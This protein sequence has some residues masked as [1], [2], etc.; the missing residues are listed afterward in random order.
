MDKGITLQLVKLNINI[1]IGARIKIWILECVGI[2]ISLHNSLKPS[3]NGCSRP[4]KPTTFGPRLRWIDAITLR[5]AKVKYATP[6]KINTILIKF[7]R[8]VPNQLNSHQ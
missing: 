6:T 3:A 7:P 2:S 8:I 1:R 4:P 5:S